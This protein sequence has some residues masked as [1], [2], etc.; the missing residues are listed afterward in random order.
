MQ[1][2]DWV[3]EKRA[4]VD[5]LKPVPSD[6]EL[7][8]TFRPA[9]RHYWRECEAEVERRRQMGVDGE[10]P[11]GNCARGDAVCTGNGD[12][13]GTAEFTLS[14]FARPCLFLR[15]DD[16]ARL[17]HAGTGQPLTKEQQQSRV[18]REDYW[19]T[20]APRFN[21]SSVTPH[22]DMHVAPVEDIDPSVAPPTPVS[23]GKLKKVWYDMRGPYQC[24]AG[25]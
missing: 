8:A 22:E 11:Q 6:E 20:V 21:D 3:R 12:G 9:E 13:T 17:A 25:I 1:F 18:C 10:Q 19:G 15:D 5:A 4:N 2:E 24:C 7:M 16:R 23:G 14:L